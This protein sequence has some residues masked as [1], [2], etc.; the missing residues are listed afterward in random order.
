MATRDRMIQ[1][2]IK[3]NIKIISKN[4]DGIVFLFSRRSDCLSVCQSTDMS[5]FVVFLKPLKPSANLCVV[6]LTNM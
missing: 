1:D 2:L 6:S 3:M 5:H 4:L